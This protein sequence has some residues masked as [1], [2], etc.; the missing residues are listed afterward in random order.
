MLSVS[1]TPKRRFGVSPTQQIV[2]HPLH[3]SELAPGAVQSEIRAMSVLADE[4]DAINLAQG[5]CDT[6]VP[7]IVAEGAARAI[8]LGHNIYTRLDGIARLRRAIAAKTERTL[9]PGEAVDPD[10][11]VVVTA[12]ATAAFFS[13]L[14]ALLNPGDEVILFEPLY[15]YHAS[16]VKAVRA[17]PIVVPF[18]AD[19]SSGRWLLNLDLVRAALTPR[20]RA[21][22][23]NTPSNPCGKVFTRAELEGLASLALEHNLFVISDEIYEYFVYGDAHHVS[24]ASIPGMRDRTILISGFSKT[25]SVTGWRVGYLVADARWIPSIGYFHDLLYICAPAPFQH[26][27]ADGLEQLDQDFYLGLAREYG[28]KREMLLS[29]LRD[30]GLTPHTPDGAYYI[31][32]DVS[33]VEG[34]TSA[35][36][37]RML[38]GKTGVAAV[39]GSAFFRPGGGE[40]LLRF[41]FAKRDTDLAEACRRLRTL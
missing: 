21:I 1:L 18:T 20:T 8:E 35:E 30:A 31:L 26:A 17:V 38:L 27:V 5:I 6:A 13:S 28:T 4:A 37:A 11:E 25:F 36:K 34:V 32:A 10:R 22:V 16:S 14:M 7:A 33:R 12:G 23:I 40:D 29:A 24:M 39:A 41:C 2:T 19:L 3:L 15:G 9:G